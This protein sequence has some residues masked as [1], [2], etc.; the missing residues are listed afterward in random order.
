M[1]STRTTHQS[2]LVVA[3]TER[4]AEWHGTRHERQ[5]QITRVR[6]AHCAPLAADWRC[7]GERQV[8]RLQRLRRAFETHA[9]ADLGRTRVQVSQL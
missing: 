6:A 2:R 8:L 4:P 9:R 1:I 7:L 3:S 5:E